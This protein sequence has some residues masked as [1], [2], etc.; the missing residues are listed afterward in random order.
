MTFLRTLLCTK[1]GQEHDP[2]RPQN[3]CPCGG[4]LYAQYDLVSIAKKLK[5][6]DLPSRPASLWRYRE[7][8]PV[9]DERNV[10][11]LGEG[12]TPLIKADQLGARLGLENLWIKD[13]SGNPTGSFKARGMAVAISKARELGITKVA[14]PSAGNAGGAAAAYAAKA[15]IDCTVFVPDDTPK[16]FVEECQACG[17]KVRLVSGSIA[18]AG[19][20]MAKEREKEGWFD[21]STLKEPYRVE[22]KKTLGYE[23]AEQFDWELPDWVIYPTGGGTGLVGMWKAFDELEKLGWIGK[24]RP[25]MVTVQASGCAPIVKAFE[26]K[27]ERTSPWPNPQT[28]A[29]GLRVPSAVGDFLM[30]KVLRESN[31]AAVAVSEEE[32]EAGQKSLAQAEGIF[33]CPETGA[34]MAGLKKLVEQSRISQQDSVVVFHTGS[35]YKYL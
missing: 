10:V 12:F 16:A 8:L 14:L 28:R 30:L 27:A 19:K 23:L 15:G 17:A 20:E 1:C 18:D 7:L 32:I 29:L 25:K 31:G 22:G 9:E 34:T 24:K 5:K 6:S 21:L 11:T 2:S 33:A 35:G 26:E 3:L 4:P 13:E